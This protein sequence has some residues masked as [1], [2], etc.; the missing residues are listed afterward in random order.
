MTTSPTPRALLRFFDPTRGTLRAFVLYL[1]AGLVL[2][3]FLFATVHRRSIA[4]I[5]AYPSYNRYHQVLQVWVEHGYFK[6]GGLAFSQPVWANPAQKVWRSN[7]LI[8]FQG[9]HLLQ[10]INY[11]FTGRYSYRLTVIHNQAIVLIT[12][13]L[14]GL[15]GMRLAMRL[16]IA[17]GRGFTLGLGVLAVYQTFP[18]N[19]QAFWELLP[20]TAMVLVATAWFLLE[21]ARFEQ[22]RDETR[23]VRLRMLAVFLMMWMEPYGTTF[24]LGGFVVALYLLA[25]A[26]LERV[27]VLRSVVLPAAAGVAMFALQLLSV[28]LMH[29]T[30]GFWSTPFIERSGLDGSTQYSPRSL[31]SVHAKMAVS[32]PAGKFLEGAVPRWNGRA[33]RSARPS[34]GDAAAAQERHVRDRARARAVSAICVRRVSSDG[35]SP[36]RLR[37]LPGHPAGLVPVRDP[38]C[39][40][41]IADQAD[42]GA[43]VRVDS[44]RLV[45]RVGPASHL[46][47]A[48]PASVTEHARP[49]PR[50]RCGRVRGRPSVPD[51]GRAW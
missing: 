31:G 5:A 17:P 34:I 23:F 16:G 45:F 27:R 25:P 33:H 4:D 51:A 30:V 1:L 42:W 14:L 20:T 6:H 9:A 19:L 12:A 49:V 38:A 2:M 10:R 15:L 46:R 32:E 24:M 18:Q 43:R 29:P 28:K 35:D 41:R 36:I 26:E 50:H 48:V 39:G 7:T 37:R 47:H 21:E 11:L 40:A 3:A 13:A 22:G 44:R 8:W